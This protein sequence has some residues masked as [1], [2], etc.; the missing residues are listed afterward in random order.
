M[1]ANT[2]ASTPRLPSIARAP[3]VADLSK[4]RLSYRQD[5]GLSAIHLAN[6]RRFHEQWII[7]GLGKEKLQKLTV[8]RLR[9]WSRWMQDE[10]LSTNQRRKTINELKDTQA[11]ERR[12]AAPVHRSRPRTDTV[13]PAGTR[14]IRRRRP[15]RGT[16][17]PGTGDDGA[18]VGDD[19]RHLASS[20]NSYQPKT[21]TTGLSRPT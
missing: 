15:L 18:S 16:A 11:R 9:E 6:V 13:H 14:T 8:A 21:D 20:Y 5:E 10:G 7:P 12:Q 3:R 4:E 17:R 2:G 19:L 1:G